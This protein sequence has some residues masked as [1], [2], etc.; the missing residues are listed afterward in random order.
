MKKA[1]LLLLAVIF[2][3]FLLSANAK[4]S[5]L[6]TVPV[7]E[8]TAK[9][10]S[11][12]KDIHFIKEYNSGNETGEVKSFNVS[13]SGDVAIIFENGEYKFVAVYDGNGNYCYGYR[14]IDS[15][16]MFI[17]WTDSGLNFGF[18]KTGYL[19]TVDANGN[20]IA[21]SRI[22]NVEENAKYIKELTELK[23][24]EL[25]GIH[26]EYKIKYTLKTLFSGGSE[27]IIKILPNGEERFIWFKTIDDND[28][29]R[30][31]RRLQIARG[32]AFCGSVSVLFVIPWIK[33]KIN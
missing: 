29:A 7:D 18:A 6:D 11:G 2:C 20:S 5:T 3:L 19:I 14:I 16:D 10:V 25:N 24:I 26:Y 33:K 21:V 8:E 17:L 15:S 13:E 22:S 30:S 27:R 23:E 4:A 1:M 32:I 9:T 31:E 28:A 12:Q